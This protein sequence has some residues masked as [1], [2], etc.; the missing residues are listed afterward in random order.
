MI[1]L[2]LA[3]RI[4]HRAPVVSP[5]PV[6]IPARP[7]AVATIVVGPPTPHFWSV[8]LPC[9]TGHALRVEG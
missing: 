3:E 6:R 8:L 2:E 1:M 5:G 9:H 7:G 4:G